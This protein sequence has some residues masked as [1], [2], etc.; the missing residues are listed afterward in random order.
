M[1]RQEEDIL[2][3]ISGLFILFILW[4]FALVVLR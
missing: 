3:A 2:I 1:T 4:V